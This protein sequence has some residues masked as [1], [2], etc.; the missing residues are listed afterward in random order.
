MA[1]G[2]V[3]STNVFLKHHIQRTYRGD[4]HHV[5]CSEEFDSAAL[6]RYASGAGVPPSSNPVD[7]YRRLKDAVKRGDTHDEKIEAQKASLASL[8]VKWAE[9]GEISESDRVDILYKVNKGPFDYWRPLIYVIPRQ[10]IEAR[11]ERV[12][13]D[14]CAGLGPEFI[15]R[16]L[17][18]NEFDIIEP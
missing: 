17:R 1:A 16:D 15:V 18:G 6:A 11:L 9:A 2:L 3:Y 5:W 12:S 13:A 7:I 10:P 8:A 4:V 14:Q